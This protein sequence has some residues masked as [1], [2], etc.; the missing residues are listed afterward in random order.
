MRAFLI[1]VCLLSI[2]I[3]SHAEP[4]G[5]TAYLCLPTDATGFKFKGGKW[6]PISFNV[7]G[8][9]WILKKYNSEWYWNEFGTDAQSEYTKCKSSGDTPEWGFMTCS[10][11]DNRMTFNSKTLRYQF[12]NQ[13]GYV[14]SDTAM[15]ANG[16]SPYM[17]I[18]K[19]TPL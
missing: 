16:Y 5:P 14:V 17:E 1:L 3:S 4:I 10:H 12:I 6:Q 8:V 7:A 2:S 19:C 9:K 13:A 18:G 15:D 11:Y